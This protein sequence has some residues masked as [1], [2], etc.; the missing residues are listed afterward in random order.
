MEGQE[1][2]DTTTRAYL[3]GVA[4]FLVVKLRVPFF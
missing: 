4:I 2:T 1:Y 3:P